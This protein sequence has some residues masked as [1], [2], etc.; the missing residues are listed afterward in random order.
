MSFFKCD[1][2]TLHLYFVFELYYVVD[3]M[4]V[5]SLIMF[6]YSERLLNVS[7]ISLRTEN[8]ATSC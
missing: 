5:L 1:I 8:K 3:G 6:I 7:P 2:L 4:I